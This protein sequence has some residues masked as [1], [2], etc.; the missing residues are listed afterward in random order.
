MFPCIEGSCNLDG[1]HACRE[2]PLWHT[3]R[4]AG[5][6]ALELLW[7]SWA[8]VRFEREG[9]SLRMSPT[10]SS[11]SIGVLVLNYNTW[12]LARRALDAAVRLEGEA[13]H[14]YVLFDDG[15][16]KP[17]PPDIDGRIRV[18]RNETN[19][20]FARALGAAFAQMKSDIVVLF[21][22]DAC[23]LTPFASQVRKRFQ[24]EQNLGQLG[25]LSQ[26]ENGRLTESFFSE[27][28]RW[29]LLLGQK[30]HG[31]VPKREPA[32]SNICVITG[33]MATR[34]DAY[35]QVGGFDEKF[36]FLDV[37]VDYSIRLRKSGWK[38]DV[39]PSIKI[40]HVGGGTTQLQRHRVLRFYKTRWY[41]LR[42]HNLIGDPRVA[43]RLILARLRF[44]Q[45]VLRLLGPILYPSPAVR[46][47]KLLGRRDVISYCREYYH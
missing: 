23:A 33:C 13:V 29:S 31:W 40:F 26:D 12:D 37:D 27:P 38:V 9:R 35:R 36:D 25:F 34:V 17:P 20:G 44:E 4:I 41:L 8:C 30:V 45:L 1:R 43:R 28:D 7:R 3:I 24:Q 22:S 21:D 15:S 18:I 42:K 5:I 16:P 32:P 14:E 47:E 39:D 46:S 11:L 19:L 6:R 2:E 10:E